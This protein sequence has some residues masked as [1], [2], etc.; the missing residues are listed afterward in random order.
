MASNDTMAQFLGMDTNL[1]KD[2]QLF[3][4]NHCDTAPF[5]PSSKLSL[6][7]VVGYGVILDMTT[8]SRI[9]IFPLMIKYINLNTFALIWSDTFFLKDK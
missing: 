9:E 3:H 7:P 1:L 5:S 6:C 8:L 4:Q 2:I